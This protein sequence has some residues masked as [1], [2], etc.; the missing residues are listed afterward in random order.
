MTGQRSEDVYR[1]VSGG[2]VLTWERQ[3]QGDSR[4][5]QITCDAA[6]FYGQ[7]LAPLGAEVA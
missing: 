2:R 1:L 5:D 3:M 7:M 6:W 4:V